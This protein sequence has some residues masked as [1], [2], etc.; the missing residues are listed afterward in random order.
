MSG[1]PTWYLVGSGEGA[2]LRR[3]GPAAQFKIRA[4]HTGG[5]LSVTDMTLDPYRL[6][7]PH[8][9]ADEDEYTYVVAGTVGVRA[10]DEEFK[11]VRKRRN[12]KAATSAPNRSQSGTLNED[13]DA[14]TGI[15]RR[16]NNEYL[17][18]Q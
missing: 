11:A 5:R 14:I 4:K 8:V 15:P 3:G 13:A 7:P 18:K 6:V 12:A 10:G 2:E 1:Q 16:R 17:I 9:H